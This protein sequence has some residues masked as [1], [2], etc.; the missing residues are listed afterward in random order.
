MSYPFNSSRHIK[1]TTTAHM[2]HG[3][4][5]DIPIGS[6][7]WNEAGLFDGAFFSVYLCEEC[8]KYLNEHAEEFEDGYSQGDIGAARRRGED[9]CEVAVE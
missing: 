8:E 6:S 5:D 2:C 7:A 9:D 4:E 1:A 3:C